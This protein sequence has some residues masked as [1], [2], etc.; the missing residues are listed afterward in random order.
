MSEAVPI[1]L[2]EIVAESKMRALV[3]MAQKYHP[4]FNEKQLNEYLQNL[5]EYSLKKEKDDLTSCAQTV[6]P[7]KEEKK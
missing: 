5:L 1:Y 6:S 4:E 3:K 7:C 2:F